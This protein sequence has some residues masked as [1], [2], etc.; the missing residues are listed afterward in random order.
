MDRRIHLD[1][2]VL[3]RAKAQ[4]VESHAALARPI[5]QLAETLRARGP[6]GRPSALER[7]IGAAIT[8]ALQGRHVAVDGVFHG[9]FDERNDFVAG[10]KTI[11]DTSSVL[12]CD[13]YL[14]TSK[15]A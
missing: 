4:L 10:P 9:V 13:N 11:N 3:S 6:P 2:I 7:L 1:Q 14:V 12:Q 15:L 8:E 5:G